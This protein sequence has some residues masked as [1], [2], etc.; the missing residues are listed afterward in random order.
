MSSLPKRYLMSFKN[1]ITI[2]LLVNAGGISKANEVSATVQKLI[3]NGDLGYGSISIGKTAR[4]NT[5]KKQLE[6]LGHSVSEGVSG[7]CYGAR[8]GKSYE[9]L[10]VY[11]DAS[12]FPERFLDS[13]GD[14]IVN[15]YTLI[16]N[17]GGELVEDLDGDIF[18]E[19]CEDLGLVVSRNNSYNYA[20]HDS[21]TPH[22]LVDFDFATI[23]GKDKAF[24]VVKFHCGGDI[25]GNY[26]ERVVFKFSSMDDIYSVIYPTCELKENS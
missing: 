22:F 2:K 12:Q 16:E 1:S 4:K 3:S 9:G 26:T 8:D 13:D 5:I 21:E 17:M 19:A 6:S 10:T 18:S 23:E 11:A 24:L 15:P 14:E 7:G 25:R 20:G